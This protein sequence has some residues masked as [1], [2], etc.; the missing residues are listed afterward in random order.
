MDTLQSIPV[1]TKDDIKV[2]KMMPDNSITKTFVSMTD[3]MNDLT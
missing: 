1:D 3:G 2:K